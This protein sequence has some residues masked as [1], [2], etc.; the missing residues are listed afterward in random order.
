[1][2]S[3]TALIDILSYSE[4]FLDMPFYTAGHM[5]AIWQHMSLENGQIYLNSKTSAWGL[6]I[7][8]DEGVFY[9]TKNGKLDA[10]WDHN[11]YKRLPDA[12]VWAFKQHSL[13]SE[14][15]NKKHQKL[16]EKLAKNGLGIRFS[17]KKDLDVELFKNALWNFSCH[18]EIGVR[19]AQDLNQFLSRDVTVM[20]HILASWD[21]LIKQMKPLGVGV[22][23]IIPRLPKTV[24]PITATRLKEKTE[25][26]NQQFGRIKLRA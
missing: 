9:L 13:W 11:S 1:M 2:I 20:Y 10:N 7:P 8:T 26:L 23:R 5:L 22:E 25:A 19:I 15:E 3:K 18:K 17:I 21:E 24:Q 4:Q 14:Q 12:S 6:E 16:S